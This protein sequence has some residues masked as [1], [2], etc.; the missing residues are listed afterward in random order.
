MHSLHEAVSDAFVAIAE[1]TSN[2]KDVRRMKV[3]DESGDRRDER[4]YIVIPVPKDLLG[5][6]NWPGL[7]SIGMVVRRHRDL[8][9]CDNLLSHQ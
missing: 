5:R 3:T 6:E 1:E 4:E 2:A 9:F 8:P 7:E